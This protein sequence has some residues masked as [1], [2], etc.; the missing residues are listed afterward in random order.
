MPARIFPP[1]GMRCAEAP[2]SVGSM[3]A[4]LKAPSWVP[5]LLSGL[6]ETWWNSS[7][8]ISRLSKAWI[9][10]S[11]TAKRKGRMGANQHLVVAG[12]KLLDGLHLGLGDARLV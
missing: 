4:G 1:V 5:S 11:S 8:A 6:A 9:P 12:E 7:T 10:S 3:A 2:S